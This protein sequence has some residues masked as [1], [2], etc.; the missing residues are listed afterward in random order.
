M[1]HNMICAETFRTFTMRIRQIATTPEPVD[2][3]ALPGRRPI[4]GISAASQ[5]RLITLLAAIFVLQPFAF[6]DRSTQQ[7]FRTPEAAASALVAAADTGDLATLRS[8]LGPEGDQI[9]SSG[10][11][12]ADDN[13]RKEFIRR[14][15]QMHRLAYDDEGRVILYIGAENWPTPI[16]LVKKDSGWIFD[17]AAGKHELLYR[18]IGRNELFTIDVLRNLTEAQQEYDATK[19]QYAEK[20]LSTP[21]RQDGLYWKTAGGQPDSP[22]GP[23]VAEASI[24]GYRRGNNGTPPP[25]HGYYYRVLTRQ[26]KNAPGGAKNYIIDGRMTNGF[27]F[28]AFPAEYRSSGVMTFM[29]NQDGIIVQKDLG[30]ETATF[31]AAIAEFNPDKTWDQVFDESDADDSD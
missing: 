20:I 26:G 9:I 17:T 19:K 28:L 10:D 11:L 21:G 1:K 7:V 18:R 14:Y 16:P 12:V 30:S 5:A 2:A 22:I 29:V 27:A 13:A 4:K 31:A 3:R 15:Q 8:I 25:F 6:A 23:L 24:E